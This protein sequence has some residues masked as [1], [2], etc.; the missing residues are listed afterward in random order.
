MFTPLFIH[1]PFIW[2]INLENLVQ[3]CLLFIVNQYL[4]FKFFEVFDVV[5]LEFVEAFF[6]PLKSISW[7]R[8]FLESG[9][10][11]HSFCR[12]LIVFHVILD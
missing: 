5:F 2:L 8:L 10:K 12:I 4:T 6:P 9:G 7:R 1:L 11:P 3:S